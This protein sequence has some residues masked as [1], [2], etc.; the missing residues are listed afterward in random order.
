MWIKRMPDRICGAKSVKQDYLNMKIKV[1][2]IVEM[3]FLTTTFKGHRA[4]YLL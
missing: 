2:R 4:L 1:V 3:A